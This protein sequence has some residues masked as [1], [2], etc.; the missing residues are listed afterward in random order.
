MAGYPRSYLRVY[1]HD[2]IYKKR[3]WPISSH[4]DRSTLV[5]T[6][7]VISGSIFSCISLA[8]LLWISLTVFSW[9]SR[10]SRKGTR[11]FLRY[12]WCH[13]WSASLYC[14]CYS[15][16]LDLVK[17]IEVNLTNNLI[18]CWRKFGLQALF[19]PPWF[20]WRWSTFIGFIQT[21]SRVPKIFVH[22]WLMNVTLIWYAVHV[23]SKVFKL[24]TEL[25]VRELSPTEKVEIKRKRNP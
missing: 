2:C 20:G 7:N 15:G 1:I 6:V 25:T 13:V 16:G 17:E 23:T 24:L 21:W 10:A 11:R 4:H 18:Y 8:Y 9:N 22:I 19:D 3:L 14:S 12:H 5:V